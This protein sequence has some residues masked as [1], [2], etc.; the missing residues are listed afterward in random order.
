MSKAEIFGASIIS[1]AEREL[2]LG[3]S[4]PMA[5]RRQMFAYPYQM[6]GEVWTEKGG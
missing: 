6:M 1:T 3:F 5:S 4:H 2:I